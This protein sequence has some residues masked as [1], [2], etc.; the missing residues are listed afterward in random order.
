MAYSSGTATDIDDFKRSIRAFAVRVL[1]TFDDP[2]FNAFGK[3]PFSSSSGTVIFRH[4]DTKAAYVFDFVNG[5]EMHGAANETVIVGQVLNELSGSSGPNYAGFFGANEASFLLDLA[6]TLSATVS[7]VNGVST[8]TGTASNASAPGPLGSLSVGSTLVFKQT[9]QTRHILEITALN[10]SSANASHTFTAKYVGS[11][12]RSSGATDTSDPGNF[13]LP[14]PY[15]GDYARSSLSPYAAIDYGNTLFNEF[16]ANLWGGVVPEADVAKGWFP[17][18]GRLRFDLGVEYEFFGSSQ[19]GDE[20]FH[21]VLNNVGSSRKHHWWMG[22]VSGNAPCL[23]SGDSPAG[24]FLGT[25][26]PHTDENGTDTYQYPFSYQDAGECWKNPS[27]LIAPITNDGTDSFKEV[28]GGRNSYGP[29]GASHD[30]SYGPTASTTKNLVSQTYSIQAGLNH[31]SGGH[32]HGMRGGRGRT[33]Y[34][35]RSGP[36]AGPLGLQLSQT[37]YYINPFVPTEAILY[38]L[39]RPEIVHT[40]TGTSEPQAYAPELDSDPLFFARDCTTTLEDGL[41]VLS[42]TGNDPRLEFGDTNTRWMTFPVVG[43]VYDTVEIRFRLRR[44]STPASVWQGVF[45]FNNDSTWTSGTYPF[46]A[47]SETFSEPS[48]FRDGEWV[49]VSI[50]PSSNAGWTG[51]ITHLRFDFITHSFS[52]SVREIIEVD[53]I[54]VGQNRLQRNSIYGYTKGAYTLI[55]Q[56]PGVWRGT[57]NA[58]VLPEAIVGSKSY[59]GR[60][61]TSR[62]SALS[63]GKQ[64]PTIPTESSSG[65]AAYFYRKG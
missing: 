47:Y 2:L 61:V 21:I 44:E 48:G 5:L 6:G 35:L 17:R 49:T 51:N 11:I 39:P 52:P 3:S 1:G 46:G 41:L 4:K 55:G 26:G 24:M 36:V 38:G 56:F 53:Y 18:M 16:S 13:S 9:P 15:T 42:G 65:W 31:F 34:P 40:R 7:V 19:L 37:S 43:A 58:Q 22:R 30:N 12:N 14:S 23:N 10:N 32:S 59:V 54:T 62:A 25:T 28:N 63:T 50:D 20:H 45:Y 64:R 57:L 29:T 8:Y 27:I 33:I 60:P